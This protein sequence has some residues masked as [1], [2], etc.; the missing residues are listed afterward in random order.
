[1]RSRTKRVLVAVAGLATVLG[2]VG[3]ANADG[4]K[5]DFAVTASP[6]GT[7][8]APGNYVV[9]DIAITRSHGF[10]GA[11]SL[12]VRGLP[13]GASGGFSADPDHSASH[14]ALTVSTSASATLGTFSLTITGTSGHLTHTSSATLTVAQPPPPSFW[15]AASPDNLTV[16]AG[17]S[18]ASTV[19]IT[20]T[21]L[22]AP[23][24]F[25]VTGVPANA[26]ATF[27]PAST[28]GNSTTLTVQTASNTPTGK[29]T[30]V[31][32]G[33]SGN[34]APSTTHVAL[35]VTK[36]PPP[37]FTLAASPDNLNVSAGL[38]GAFTVSIAR[39]N[40]SAPVAFTVTG[41]PA[42][43]TATFSPTS[44]SGN[45]TTLTLQTASDTPTG[46][47]T[48]V[49]RGTSGTIAASTSA[50][51]TVSAAHAKQFTIAGSLDRSLSPGVSGYLN[52]ALTNPNNQPLSITGLTVTVTGT[53]KS[54][55]TTSNF[56]ATQFSG[57][58]PLTVPA[59]ATRTLSQLGLA[60]SIWP[61]VTMINLPTNQDSCKDTGLTLGYTGS[62]QGN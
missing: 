26:V 41:V 49:I 22:S 59:N 48:L 5:P 57:V 12:A 40:L 46:S 38:S 9:Y 52:L 3:I 25:T 34:V 28:S 29:A 44:T 53:S 13:A 30:L 51:L 16:S 39:T 42:H 23:V 61:K 33:T 47:Y 56:S 7:S 15:L 6:H 1:M 54:G 17:L 62:G 11:V 50:H 58:Y 55:C 37:S 27:S 35:T 60:Q 8:V 10:Q 2:L 32:K 18:G 43:A 19:T 20:R 21:N 14:R 45:S 24:A 31:I 36:P 4:A